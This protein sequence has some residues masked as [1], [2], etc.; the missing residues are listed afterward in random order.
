MSQTAPIEF[1]ISIEQSKDALCQKI[2]KYLET[3]EADE[4]HMKNPPIW[5]KEI[6]CYTIMNGILYRSE[7]KRKHRSETNMQI[8]LPLSLRPTVLKE[9]HNANTAAH[10]AFLRTYNKVKNN[11]YW[12][13]MKKDIEEYCKTC[14][15]CI[16]NTKTPYRALLHPLELATEPFQVIG[17]D[18]LGPIRP[19]SPNG[20]NFIMV[21]TDYFTKW[22][23][24]IPLP[25]QKA[26]TTADALYKHILQ[27]HGL[28]KTIITDRGTNFTSK[29][30]EH[31]CAK[32]KI[33][34]RLTTAY[35]PASNG[36]TERFNRTLTTMLRKVLEDGFHENWEDVRGD[37]CFAY[38]ST[39]H[40]STLESPYYLLHGR[41]PNIPINIFLDATPPPV[42]ANDYLAKLSERLRVS[43]QLTREAN[44]RAREKQKNQYDKRARELNYKIGDRV[45]LDIKTVDPRDSRKFTSL[46]KGPFRVVKIYP[47]KTVDIADPS[48]TVQK[49][50]VNRLKPLFETMLW[51]DNPPEIDNNLETNY[52]QRETENEKPVPPRP[53]RILRP[54]STLK[55][56]TRYRN[57]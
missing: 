16:A 53:M 7:S 4:K 39:T 41:D 15:T 42:Q 22:V 19:A 36:E 29:L 49:V 21:I 10:F 25:D 52:L 35:H 45:L 31:L 18:F 1:A 55:P 3:G 48:F 32:L 28:P 9:M 40:S 34:H 54:R 47:N 46:Y 33:E 23:E 2:R 30:F 27:R 5:I 50:H 11:Y 24:A 51:K 38:R 26:I 43:F 37:I 12:P 6:E 44:L 13:T 17:I 57:I 8:V 14:E 20:N 56:P